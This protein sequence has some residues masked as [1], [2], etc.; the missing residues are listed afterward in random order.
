MTL[1]LVTACLFFY[2]G[3][4]ILAPKSYLVARSSDGI[5]TFAVFA[6]HIKND[7]GYTNYSNM[8]YPYGQ[9][10][11]FTD[12]QTGLANAFK[13]IS[14]KISFF[15]SHSVAL[16]NLFLIFSYAGCAFFLCLI[17]QRL[18]MSS[19][20]IILGSVGITLMSPQIFRLA[21]H[22]T[23]AYAVFFPLSWWLLIRFFESGKS[24]LFTIL[25]IL[26]S[27]AWFFIHPYYVILNAVFYLGYYAVWLVQDPR[28]SRQISTWA[29][30]VFQIVL[31]VLITRYYI[32]SVDHHAGR[33]EYPF[34]FWSYYAK[35]NT[36]FAP[37][38]KPFNGFFQ[39]VFHYSTDH[40]NWEGWSYIGLGALAVVFY[41]VFRILR[42]L[43]NKKIKRIVTPVLPPVL[44]TAVWA[45]VLALIFA[46]CM[47]FRL[48]TDLLYNHL[49]FIQQFRSLGRFA[50]IFYYVF[51]VYALYTC[52]LIHRKWMM[53][54]RRVIALS[55]SVI[56]FSLYFVESYAYHRENSEHIE[57]SPNVFNLS[58]V[59]PDTRALIDKI[60][61]IKS[62]YQCI[63]P[64]P[65]YNV[66]NENF[67]TWTSDVIL[68]NSFVV[69]HFTNMPLFSNSAARSPIPEAKKNM[70]FFT[71]PLI[72]KEIRADLPTTKPFLILCD[73]EDVN[74]EEQF[75]LRNSREIFQNGSYVVYELPYDAVFTNISPIAM[76]SFEVNREKLVPYHGLLATALPDTVVYLSFDEFSSSKVF[77]GKGA[78]TGIK[79]NFVYAFERRPCFL[80]K[81]QD[82]ILSFWY[83]NK[84]ELSNQVSCVLEEYD[85]DGN[86]GAWEL[87]WNPMV[88]MKING[89]WSLVEKKFR[90]K[91]S[92][93]EFS[94]FFRGNDHSKQEF[95][96]DDLIIRP[97]GINVYYDTPPGA[98]TYALDMVSSLCMKNQAPTGEALKANRIADIKHAIRTSPG[99]LNDVQKKANEKRIPLDSMITLDAVYVFE[100][101]LK[102]LK[103]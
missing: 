92:T 16:F 47:P 61:S 10:H 2:Y 35:L 23:L 77:R 80:K 18:R 99:W 82:Y 3:K 33:S 93:R 76:K 79:C 20:F 55:F 21:N 81:D 96:A 97:A 40:Q 43:K 42:Y 101:E 86:A 30:A 60:N 46:M 26:N 52:Y 7:T 50:W 45:S 66:G 36:V 5:K 91:E 51:T 102:Q 70:Q 6:G 15:D 58:R 72:P 49:A 103:N 29:H 13:F 14:K 95:F 44:R 31:P 22:P 56:L 54:G 62:G 59:T 38:A 87:A 64:F 28:V 53:K 90:V 78:L 25:I 32:F 39:K 41:S 67:T 19:V 94:L 73:R 8:N 75:W 9:T 63:I 74:E 98:E 12:G 57:T 11:I 4:V 34:G 24:W 71:P 85:A 89:D 69:S 100:E 84:E 1:L 17:L 88:S 48:F 68:A 83:Y 65:Y 27:T 37:V